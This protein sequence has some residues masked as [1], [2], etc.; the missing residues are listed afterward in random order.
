MPGFRMIATPLVPKP[1][2]GSPLVSSWTT[3]ISRS[4]LRRRGA[5]EAP[6]GDE[7]RAC[8]SAGCRGRS[9]WSPLTVL[10][11]PTP[12]ERSMR[13]TPLIAEGGVRRA[14]GEEAGDVDVDV[15]AVRLAGRRRRLGLAGDDDLAV[16]LHDDAASDLS[17]PVGRRRAGVQPRQERTGDHVRDRHAVVAEALDQFAGSVDPRQHERAIGARH[18]RVADVIGAAARCT[19]GVVVAVAHRRQRRKG[20][21]VDAE[22][23]VEAG[24]LG[25]RRGGQAGSERQ[26]PGQEPRVSP[27]HDCFL[28]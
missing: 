2:S 26:R 1:G 20:G 11:A 21:A 8:R 25:R 5:V 4:V 17:S 19:S 23:V 14:V 12:L 10:P 13:L 7:Q 6:R 28:H 15:A 3:A 16:G 9:D 24:C 22:R 18:R 27:S